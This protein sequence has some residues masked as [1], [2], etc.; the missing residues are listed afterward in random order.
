MLSVRRRKSARYSLQM[1]LP[2][3]LY[4]WLYVRLQKVDYA[5][6]GLG[7]GPEQVRDP[8][9]RPFEGLYLNWQLHRMV[10]SFLT[11]WSI[12]LYSFRQ[13]LPLNALLLFAG[14][15]RWWR[16]KCACGLGCQ[17]RCRVLGL[18]LLLIAFQPGQCQFCSLVW[19]GPW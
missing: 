15:H 12:L 4:T 6:K 14:F 11:L 10:Y 2:K 16:M 7:G 18:H 3:R 1:I 17:R 8:V 19:L 9:R 13:A 5:H